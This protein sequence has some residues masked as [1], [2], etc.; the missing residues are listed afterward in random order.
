MEDGSL[1]P[2]PSPPLPSRHP[3]RHPL[4][5]PREGD[6][7]AQEESAERAADNLLSCEECWEGRGLEQSCCLLLLSFLLSFSDG[8]GPFSFSFSYEKYWGGLCEKEEE[9]EEEEEEEREE[10]EEEEEG[11][12]DVIRAWELPPPSLLPPFLFHRVFF[13]FPG[14]M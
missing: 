10:E 2:F 8:N 6:V 11:S 7:S 3:S 1:S 14:C 12:D 5:R 9:E 4:I 13:F